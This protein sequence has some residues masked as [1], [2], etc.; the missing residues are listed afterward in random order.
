MSFLSVIGLQRVLRM[1]LGVFKELM[2][3]VESN[4]HSCADMLLLDIIFHRGNLQIV[5]CTGANVLNVSLIQ[6]TSRC[7]ANYRINSC[8]L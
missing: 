8:K 2:V 3:I 6:N 5:S 1:R 7:H 4:L